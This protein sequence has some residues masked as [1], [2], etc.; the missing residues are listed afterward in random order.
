MIEFQVDDMT[1]GGCAS[2]ITKAVKGVTPAASVDINLAAHRVRVQGS[3][4]VPEEIEAAIKDAGYT[5]ARV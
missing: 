1:C 5:P 2:R 4:V 3:G